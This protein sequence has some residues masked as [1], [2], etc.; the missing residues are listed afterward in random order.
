MKLTCVL[1]VAVLFLTACQLTTAASYARSERQHPDLGSSDQNS[2]L[3]K[4]CLG[5]GE[6]C[7]LDSSCCSFSCT[8]NV[9]F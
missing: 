3:T 7:W 5:S 1:I 4:R 9:C 8:N 6:T 2:K